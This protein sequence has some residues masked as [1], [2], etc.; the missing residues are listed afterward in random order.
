MYENN[1]DVEKI[2]KRIRSIRKARGMKQH[3]LAEK[4]YLSAESISRMENGKVVCMPEHI[5]NLCEIF[6]VSADYFYFGKKDNEMGA[7]TK[8]DIQKDIS[9]L[10]KDCSD[11]ELVK[12]RLMVKIMLDKQI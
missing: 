11:E 4:M 5:A 9:L 8:S 6:D 3:E 12:V 2:G 10:L 1:Y 7:E